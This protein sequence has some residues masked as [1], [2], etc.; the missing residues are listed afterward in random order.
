M[1]SISV[2]ELFQF[3]NLALSRFIT[4]L[5][6]LNSLKMRIREPRVSTYASWSMISD[7]DSIPRHRGP[8]RETRSGA[9]W[10]FSSRSQYSGPQ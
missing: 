4:T 5:Q 9:E 2:T 7:E 8:R 1:K 6:R 10:S 3:T